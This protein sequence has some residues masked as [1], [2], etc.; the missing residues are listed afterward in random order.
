MFCF[1]TT[2]AESTVGAPGVAAPVTALQLLVETVH[3]VLVLRPAGLLQSGHDQIALS[4]HIWADVMG[5]LQ[6]GMAQAHAFVERRGTKPHQTSVLEFVPLPEPDVM[7][8][9]WAAADGQFVGQ[10]LTF[11]TLALGC[12][13]EKGR[14]SH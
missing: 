4:V 9:A 8:L 14:P 7:T 11:A 5:D 3:E 10:E 2:A 6:I 12:R 1:S 13:Y